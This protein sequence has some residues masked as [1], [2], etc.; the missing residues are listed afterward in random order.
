[1][2]S[3]DLQRSNWLVKEHA[4]IVTCIFDTAVTG[5]ASH[6]YAIPLLLTSMAYMPL[7]CI[8]PLRHPASID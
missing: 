1:M 6:H 3:A 2:I 7:F 4:K 5:I 8:T